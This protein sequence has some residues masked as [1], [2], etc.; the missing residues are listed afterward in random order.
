MPVLARYFSAL[1]ATL[2]GSR[3]YGSRVNGSCT[4]KLRFS[5][6]AWVNRSICAVSGSGRSNMSDSWI[7]WNPR[8][9]EPSKASPSSN[10]LSS[11]NEIG[12]VK[13]CMMPGRSQNRTST[14]STCSSLA[15]LKMSSAVFS[16]TEALS[17]AASFEQLWSMMSFSLRG[18]NGTPGQTVWTRC[19]L[20]QTLC[21]IDVTWQ[22]VLTLLWGDDAQ[23]PP[24]TIRSGARRIGRGPGVSAPAARSA[25]IRPGFVGPNWPPVGGAAGRLV[26]CLRFGRPRDD[27]G[28]D[29]VAHAVD[30]GPGDLAGA[31]DRGRSVVRVHPGPAGAGPAGGI[32]RRAAAR[33]NGPGRGARGDDRVRHT[34]VV[35]RRRR[36]GDPGPR[37]GHRR[38]AA[39]T[40]DYPAPPHR[41]ARSASSP[42]V[43][44][45]AH[46]AL[47]AAHLGIAGHRALGH[48]GGPG[49]RT[50][51]AQPRLQRGHLLDGDV[52]RQLGEVA[53]QLGERNLI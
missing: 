53:L 23:Q 49:P 14:N 40:T 32:R 36:A 33:G 9:D 5:V 42:V 4:K 8:I 22:H 38:R 18:C 28:A 45:P 34:R 37:D 29:P 15:S 7:D 3:E 48:R 51:C 10:T 52:G 27:A 31:R 1:R 26:A 12:I 6:L 11:K 20:S 41:A 39:L 43:L 46:R 13:C 16:D 47:D 35:C 21:Y 2:R 19:R 44:A 25:R 24:P 30:G 17:F 50:Q